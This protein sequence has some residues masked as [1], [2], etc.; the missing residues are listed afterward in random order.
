MSAPRSQT[1]PRLFGQRVRELRLRRGLSQG[2]LADRL[3]LH[4]TTINKIESGTLG[5][6]S[7]SQLFAFAEA[8]G[9]APIYLLTPSA[10]DSQIELTSGGRIVSADEARNWIRGVP[11]D[12]AD[13][14]EFFLDLP[15]SEQRHI[16]RRILRTS[17]TSPAERL[18]RD[19]SEAE[20]WVAKKIEE[21]LEALQADLSPTAPRKR[22]DRPRAVPGTQTA[23]RK[24]KEDE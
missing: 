20:E 12:D 19:T 17:L 21:Q 9:T 7:L 1:I 11:P 6:V 14:L 2:E 4:R 18:W 22:R 16:L 23:K 8:L 15:T 24:R 3:H 5:D 13:Q 10:D